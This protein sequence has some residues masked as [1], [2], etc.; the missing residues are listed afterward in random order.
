M[1]TAY[2]IK[3]I[4]VAKAQLGISDDDYRD[5]LK[6]R[7]YGKKSSKHLS[8]KE[9]ADLIAHFE[10]CGF[11]RFSKSRSTRFNELESRPGMASPR[12][13]RKIEAMW[14]DM[15]KANSKAAALRKFLWREV[16]VTDLRF[17]EK[18]KA[19]KMIEILKKIQARKGIS[20]TA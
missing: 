9:A 16:K 19:H 5:M 8:V 4:H 2:Q 18:H 12:Q 13:L 11:K 6:E 10:K 14:G 3:I 20:Q 15:C 1:S 7:Y 17:L